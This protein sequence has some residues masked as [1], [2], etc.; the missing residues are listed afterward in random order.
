MDGD[1][2]HPCLRKR[3]RETEREREIVYICIYCT[4]TYLHKIKNK[5]NIKKHCLW[6]CTLYLRGG[7]EEFSSGTSGLASVAL[8]S[9][10]VSV[11]VAIG[12][13]ERE[14]IKRFGSFVLERERERAVSV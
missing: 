13:E 8:T 1:F 4:Q 3:E 14:R 5:K 6:L 12:K 10:L 7:S 2:Q 11:V 9:V